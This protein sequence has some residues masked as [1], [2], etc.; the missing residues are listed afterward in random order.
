MR[1]AP[2]LVRIPDVS[3]ISWERLPGGKIPRE[4]IA[5]VVPDLAVEVISKNNTPEEL[6]SKLH[7]YLTAGVRQAWYIYP[8]EK[9]VRVY[10]S[11]KQFTTLTRQQTLEGGDLAGGICTTA[12]W[13]FR[14]DTHYGGHL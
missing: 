1:L 9:E 4:V 11:I 10:L 7:D 3:F 14:T 6:R 12:G 5:D 13:L 2:G 8:A